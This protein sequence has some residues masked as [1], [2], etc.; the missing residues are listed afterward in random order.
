MVL[1]KYFS[2]I[3]FL[4]GCSYNINMQGKITH[5]QTEDGWKLSLEHFVPAKGITKKNP[6][7]LCH[8]LGASRTYYKLNEERSMVQLL[9]NQGYEVFLLDLRG[10]YSAGNPG[11]FFGDKT[12][13]YNFDDYVIYDMDAAITEVLKI[14]G[15]ESVN[16]VGHS[17]GGM[18]AYSRIGSYGEKRIANLVTIGSPFS[19]SEPN[20]AIKNMNK[21]KSMTPLLPV[22]PARRLARIKAGIRVPILPDGSVIN[23][24]YWPDN[25]DLN[26]QRGMQLT[27]VNDIAIPEINQFSSWVEKGNIHS[28]DGKIIYSKNLK[29]IKIPTLLV[30]GTRDNLAPGMVVRRVYDSIGSK[31]K[32]IH[33][34]GRSQGHSEDYGHTDLIVGRN[35]D[36]EALFPIV[37]WLNERN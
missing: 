37:T 2:I 9:L 20:E 22:V 25:I 6:V 4:I 31:D 23:L 30:W 19:F 32:S 28:N 13:S 1:K 15:K 12:F 11:L 33:I 5:P 7:I 34:V 26:I 27:T 36:K 14:S 10:R 17:M 35:A 24:I 3:F 29:N 21:M 16:W 18:I 8:G